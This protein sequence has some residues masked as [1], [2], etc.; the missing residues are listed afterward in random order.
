MKQNYTK[1]FNKQFDNPMKQLDKLIVQ[2][3]E[4]NDDY[5]P[6]TPE[7]MEK[8]DAYWESLRKGED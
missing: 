5:E 4:L 8:A 7:E 2:A 1:Q 3:K 6:H